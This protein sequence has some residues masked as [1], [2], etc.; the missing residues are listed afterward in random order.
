MSAENSW[1]VAR[2]QRPLPIQ[3]LQ[4]LMEEVN[5]LA[6]ATTT[7]DI[8]PLRHTSLFELNPG[9]RRVPPDHPDFYESYRDVGLFPEVNRAGPR[10]IMVELTRTLSGFLLPLI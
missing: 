2:K 6:R 3:V 4:S 1:V 10:R 8:W 5:D 9:A 7:L